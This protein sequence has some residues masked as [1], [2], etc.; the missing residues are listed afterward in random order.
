[1]RTCILILALAAAGCEQSAADAGR[2]RFEDPRGFSESSLNRMACSDCHSAEEGGDPERILPG[3]DLWGTAARD[4]WWGG[5]SAT[6]ADAVNQCIVYF[7]LGDE[8]DLESDAARQLDEF[9]LS[10]TPEGSDPTPLPMTIVENIQPLPPGDAAAGEAAYERT[11]GYCHGDTGTG[12]GGLSDFILPDD[13]SEYDEIFGPEVPK[14]LIVTEATRHGR[15]F[16][17][18]GQMPFFSV[19]RLSDED[20]SD[21]LAYLGLP[22]E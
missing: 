10:I 17:I 9:L 12:A 8:L 4:A 5:Q 2:E 14:G 20:I 22:S 19:E 11:C 18:G 6:L 15:F 1:V 3:A 13:T 7:L 16:G 21:I